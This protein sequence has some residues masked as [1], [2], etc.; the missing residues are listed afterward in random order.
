MAED[1]AFR[2]LLRRVRAGDGD[3]STELVR[4][5]GPALRL[6]AHVRLKEPGLRRLLDTQDV[7]QSVLASFFLRAAAG[8]YDLETP[9]QLLRLLGAM[10]RNKIINQAAKQRAARRDCRRLRWGGSAVERLV[11][12]GSGPGDEVA[13]RELLS[14][15]RRRLSEGERRLADQRAAGRSWNEIAAE[16][17][18]PANTLRMRLDRA[19]ERVS[20]ELGLEV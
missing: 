15:F 17:G 13:G 11:A 18:E 7:C 8:Q 9:G 20:R 19:V 10:A 2:D 12:P 5:Y 14:E 3:A 6:A 16:A 1:L 4:R